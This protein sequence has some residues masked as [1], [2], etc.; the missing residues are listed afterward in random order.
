MT[1][2]TIMNEEFEKAKQHLLKKENRQ[3]AEEEVLSQS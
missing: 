1:Q 3:K 2:K